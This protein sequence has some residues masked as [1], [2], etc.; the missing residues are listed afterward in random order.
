MHTGRSPVSLRYGP[1]SL[2]KKAVYLALNA[3]ACHGAAIMS[4][5]KEGVKR[6][7]GPLRPQQLPVPQ[8]PLQRWLRLHLAELADGEVKVLRPSS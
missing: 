6:R 1:L 3:F 7:V 2:T 5:A 8:R 4:L